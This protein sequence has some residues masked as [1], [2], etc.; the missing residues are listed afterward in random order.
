MP[1]VTRCSISL[2]AQHIF[3][4][5]SYQLC[6][7][8]SLSTRY[9]PCSS[10]PLSLQASLMTMMIIMTMWWCWWWPDD[11]R[12]QGAPGWSDRGK[13][14]ISA[15]SSQQN[16]LDDD[17]GDDEAGDSHHQP[18]S[19]TMTMNDDGNNPYH[20]CQGNDEKANQRLASASA[21]FCNSS[22]LWGI[23]KTHLGN[24]RQRLNP[25]L[26]DDDNDD[27]KVYC[28]ASSKPN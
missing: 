4:A 13:P 17:D 20:D 18:S 27:V 9:T 21:S 8:E 22:L 5:G 3:A 11:L 6:T 19:F 25:G 24:H 1:R 10:L 2:P 23:F 26:D 15:H 28:E 16:N 12:A 14:L 7:Q